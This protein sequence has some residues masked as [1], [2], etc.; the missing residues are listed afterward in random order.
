MSSGSQLRKDT[1]FLALTQDLFI[2][3]N[4]IIEGWADSVGQIQQRQHIEH[5][6]LLGVASD[7][8]VTSRCSDGSDGGVRTREIPLPRTRKSE[9]L[10][11]A[12]STLSTESINSSQVCPCHI[13][14][15]ISW[16]EPNIVICVRFFRSVVG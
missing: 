1:S 9:S 15:W 3:A 5:V 12:K 10:G 8:Q 11:L 6:V 4:L 16:I 14:E 7:A 13:I 2:D